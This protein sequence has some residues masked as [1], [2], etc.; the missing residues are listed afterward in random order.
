[1]HNIMSIYT[2]KMFITSS[3]RFVVIV[4]TSKTFVLNISMLSNIFICKY[5]YIYEKHIFF[6]KLLL[7]QVPGTNTIVK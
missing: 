5:I 2:Q 1:M 4:H 7:K 3:L 6:Y